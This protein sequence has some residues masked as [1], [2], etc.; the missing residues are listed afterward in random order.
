MNHQYNQN[1]S[2]LPDV[3]YAVMEG[4]EIGNRIVA[5]KRGETGYFKT[6]YDIPQL[7]VGQL[8]TVV[9]RLNALLEVSSQQKEAMLA[10]SM[11]G[12]HVKGADPDFHT[13]K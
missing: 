4:N 2:K 6:D 11:F 9:N 12:W 10:G 7:D 8:E 1:F 13:P 3:C 5:L